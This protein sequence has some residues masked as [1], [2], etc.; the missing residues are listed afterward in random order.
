MS[1]IPI[2]RTVVAS[3]Q[4]MTHRNVHSVRIMVKHGAVY[5]QLVCGVQYDARYPNFLNPKTG[6][7]GSKLVSV[8][9]LGDS[10]Y[11]YLLKMWVYHGGRNNLGVEVHTCLLLRGP[12][13]NTIMCC[14]N[15]YSH[16]HI[17][18]Q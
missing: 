12:F 2:F 15:I 11:E 5:S 9:A 18:I 10:F 7:W 1:I 14:Q 13:M 3:I 17:H 6:K 4:V 16:V 8:G